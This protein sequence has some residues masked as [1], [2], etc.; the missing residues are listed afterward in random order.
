MY[1]GAITS[2]LTLS[3]HR[4]KLVMGQPSAEEKMRNIIKK[5]TDPNPRGGLAR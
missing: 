2:I 4:I 3:H 1:R 5:V